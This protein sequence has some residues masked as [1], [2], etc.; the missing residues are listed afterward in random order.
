MIDKS[1]LDNML[2]KLVDLADKELDF[3]ISK[4]VFSKDLAE[5]IILAIAYERVC[6]NGSK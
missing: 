5:S 2:I 1:K 3:A 6:N 4:K